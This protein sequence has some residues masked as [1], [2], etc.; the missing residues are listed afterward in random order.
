MNGLT[1][2]R[3]NGSTAARQ[4]GSTTPFRHYD[5]IV[6]L[7]VAV[8]LISNLASVKILDLLWFTF[9]GGTIL[10][11]LSYI[12]G[13]IL[14]EVY[15]YRR[16]RRVIWSGFFAAALMAVVLFIVDKLPPA[17]GW[18]QQEAFSAL[19]GQ[20][21]RIVL[22]SFIAYLSGE[23]TNSVILAKMK[24]AMQG[25]FLW[26]RTI[27]STLA[28]EGV[29]TLLFVLIAFAGA[30]PQSLLISIIIS[31]YVFKCGVEILMTP[32]TYKIVGYLKHEEEIDHYDRD[33]N[34][35]PFKLAVN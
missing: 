34:F 21:P 33:T 18:Q 25:R 28:G 15:G 13:D 9:D 17:E 32:V 31:N 35:N 3:G 19:L 1:D 29:D 23:F 6:A 16:A 4:H 11:P 30:L 14:T 20:T 27:G 7:F 10:F 26:M 2:Q 22:A 12:F 5:Q 24:V 8:V